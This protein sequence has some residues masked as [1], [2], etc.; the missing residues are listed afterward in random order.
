MV[1]SSRTVPAVLPILKEVRGRMALNM[2]KYEDKVDDRFMPT[3]HY[4]TG[5]RCT[6]HNVDWLFCFC[7]VEEIKQHYIK[8]MPC[9]KDCPYD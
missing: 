9:H 1:L 2:G 6:L 8:Q 5:I 7:S 4:G 3:V